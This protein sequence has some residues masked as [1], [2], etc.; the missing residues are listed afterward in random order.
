MIAE[1]ANNEEIGFN[2]AVK[3]INDKVQGAGSLTSMHILFVLTLKGKSRLGIDFF[4][5]KRLHQHK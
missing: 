3:I 2:E 1:K 5:A 4:L